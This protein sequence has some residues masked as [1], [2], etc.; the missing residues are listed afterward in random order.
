MTR[1]AEFRNAQYLH[2]GG[3]KGGKH[4]ETKE[5]DRW[6]Q[7][8][9]RNSQLSDFEVRRLSRWG[10]ATMLLAGLAAVNG[11]TPAQAHPTRPRRA[12]QSTDTGTGQQLSPMARNG[13]TAWAGSRANTIGTP[14]NDSPALSRTPVPQSRDRKTP[15][16]RDT[17]LTRSQRAS[18]SRKKRNGP[19]NRP[20]PHTEDAFAAIDPWL[21]DFTVSSQ[22]RES[23]AEKIDATIRTVLEDVSGSA[24]ARTVNLDARFTAFYHH[25][26][27]RTDL[28][29]P[30]GLPEKRREF[31]L[32]EVALG[33]MHRENDLTSNGWIRTYHKPP[34]DIPGPLITAALGDAARRKVG[35]KVLQDALTPLETPE[36]KGAYTKF[37]EN[38]IKGAAARIV[39]R[40]SAQDLVLMDALPG[41]LAGQKKP[42]LVI[43]K[44]QVVPNL[45]ALDEGTSKLLL[46][47]ATGETFMWRDAW[48][49][50][51][52]EEFI[53]PHLS[54]FESGRA[55][56]EDFQDD[57]TTRRI[58]GHDARGL[59]EIQEELGRPPISAIVF[60]E[61]DSPFER[62]WE[63]G[64]RRIRED[65]NAAVYTPE[66]QQRDQGLKF[67]RNSM[68]ALNN[69]ATLGAM[70]TTGGTALG[71]SLVAGGAGI[72]SSVYQ[73]QL[74]RVA[75]RGDVRREAE[76]DA[77]LGMVFAIGG[78]GL[79]VTAAAK[80]LRAAV[81][82]AAKVQRAK[83]LQ[84]L[85]RRGQGIVRQ[86]RKR[87]LAHEIA[88]K[89]GVARGVGP[90]QKASAYASA[91]A[92]NK[93]LA[94]KAFRQ[95]DRGW[96]AVLR[97]DELAGVIDSAEA[98]RLRD[99]TR[100]SSFGDFLGG[101]GKK[102]VLGEENLRRI[103]PGQRVAIIGFETIDGTALNRL[104]DIPLAEREN[105]REVMLHAMTAT[106]NGKV[107]GLNNAGINPHLKPRYSEFDL[108]DD[109]GLTLSDGHWALAEGRGVKVYV[110][111]GA[112]EFRIEPVRE[113]KPVSSRLK[114]SA[115]EPDEVT[116]QSE[117]LTGVRNRPT[118][119]H[120]LDDGV[121]RAGTVADMIRNPAGKCKDLMGPVASYMKENGFK[122]I[123]YRGMG[124][125]DNADQRTYANHYVVVGERG[126]KRWAFDLSAGQFD[127]KGM[128]GLHGPIVDLEENWAKTYADSTTRKLIKY[129]DFKKP[130]EATAEFGTV[131]GLD[132]LDY[133]PEA[134]VLHAPG[135]FTHVRNIPPADRTVHVAIKATNVLQPKVT[136]VVGA[137]PSIQHHGNNLDVTFNGL[138]GQTA[139]IRLHPHVSVY[140]R[141]VGPEA[142]EYTITPDQG[143][144]VVFE[145]DRGCLVIAANQKVSVQQ[146]PQEKI[147]LDVSSE[148]QSPPAQA[149]GPN[150]AAAPVAQQPSK[151]ANAP[152]EER[153][154]RP[155]IQE[156]S[157]AGSWFSGHAK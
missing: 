2:M 119:E 7:Q 107:A 30:K 148:A 105:V 97:V 139:D 134:T 37:A 94:Q 6:A 64:L 20:S 112:P 91:L 143:T 92:D 68:A 156:H 47:V 66:E 62:L 36:I 133:M 70:V 149:A 151:P 128:Q 86:G 45:V 90:V 127:N 25:A 52:L 77:E 125:W 65:A 114:Q 28:H 152:A 31:T 88:R 120:I 115:L 73:G 142:V 5:A 27:Q 38:R 141:Y 87:I 72:A 123:R 136:P 54:M 58:S 111:A 145:T 75:D 51:R 155:Q 17:T 59:K 93:D 150:L 147:T 121:L 69:L 122:N 116:I 84:S 44:G 34:K 57:H 81:G 50:T 10:Q 78:T 3:Q 23:A 96:D 118:N 43:L 85:V 106:K 108:I 98:L 140:I 35:D 15:G 13:L 53:R 103:P 67:G 39:G 26:L 46:S 11:F 21:Q 132:P 124:I 135:W 40:T 154:P 126:G 79:D 42:Q 49:S 18:L 74:A 102:V 76:D 157:G 29:D 71:L 104:T 14:N 130:Q 55:E 129:Q 48:N 138:T 61:S 100:G 137:R 32:R 16:P 144:T 95:G 19:E 146:P 41:Y 80:F 9:M 22:D 60:E 33:E 113:F 110:G 99:A 101:P 56:P 24:T 153:K 117:L 82:P 131:T 63:A 1:A 12:D 83:G 8:T 109:A 4:K 89:A